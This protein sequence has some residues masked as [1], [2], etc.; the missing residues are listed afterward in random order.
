MNT[1][2]NDIHILDEDGHILNRNNEISY[3]VHQYDRCS[4]EI[5]AKLSN[6]YNF[7]I[8]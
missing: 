3:V 8:N 7:R 6:K 5:R 2:G 4:N 1:I